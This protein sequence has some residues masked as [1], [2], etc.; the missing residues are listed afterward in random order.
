MLPRICDTGDVS[1][2][3]QTSSV[4]NPKK[5][6]V[7]HSWPWGSRSNTHASS[8][9]S[10]PSTGSVVHETL[11]LSQ[12]WGLTL[13]L[14]TS[15]GQDHG[16]HPAMQTV[17]FSSATGSWRTR[18]PLLLSPQCTQDWALEWMGKYEVVTVSLQ[19]TEDE[20]FLDCPPRPP[21]KCSM[22]LYTLLPSKCTGMHVLN[23]WASKEA[24][25]RIT[26]LVTKVGDDLSHRDR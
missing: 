14:T 11:A 21:S 13:K 23:H 7:R 8:A 6:T 10:P 20:P 3:S 5:Q 17:T 1:P 26:V 15:R 19:A 25:Q 2:G 24:Q 12:F 9:Q 16:R 4:P 22:C 18:M